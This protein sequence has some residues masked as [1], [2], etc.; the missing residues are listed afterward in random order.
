MKAILPGDVGLAKKMAHA[1]INYVQETL[2]GLSREEKRN[3]KSQ[4]R[5][6]KVTRELQR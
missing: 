1:H 5:L 4:E 6:E 3:R 2:E